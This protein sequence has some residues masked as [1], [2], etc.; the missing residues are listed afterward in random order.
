MRI[1]NPNIEVIPGRQSRRGK[2]GFRGPSCDGARGWAVSCLFAILLAG[3][4]PE[5]AAPL[6]LSPTL[7][8]V[9]P[10]LDA[11]VRRAIL[12][13]T[14]DIL[15]SDVV[16]LK[17]FSAAGRGIVSLEG[18]EK[19]TALTSLDLS[20]NQIENIRPLSRLTALELLYLNSNRVQDISALSGMTLLT[21]LDLS[22][23]RITNIAALSGLT[24]LGLFYFNNNQV[25]DIS[26]LSNMSDMEILYLGGNQ[27]Q[28]LS[29]LV[30]LR[31]LNTLSLSGNGLV[32]ISALTGLTKLN[33]LSL[34]NNQIRDLSALVN[35]PGIQTFD[36]VVLSGNPLDAMSLDT[37]VPALEARRVT[38]ILGRFDG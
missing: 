17:W 1:F 18:I 27:I 12:K 36:T 37:Q 4:A 25:S 33:F 32:D 7:S 31:L 3:C 26:P 38:V 10:E 23:N 24:E 19:L 15:P 34:S 9:D 2:A 21:V 11:A 8:F 6:P 20:G 14:G 16:G 5:G 29:P 22:R 13:P 28:D 35:N 30:H